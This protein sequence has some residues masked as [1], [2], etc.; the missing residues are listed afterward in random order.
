MFIETWLLSVIAAA[1]ISVML[2]VTRA[3]FNK[4]AEEGCDRTLKFLADS[5]IIKITGTDIYPYL[6]DD[7]ELYFGDDDAD[8]ID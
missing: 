5:K 7:E 1:V 2:Y 4:G 6:G 8:R 3:A